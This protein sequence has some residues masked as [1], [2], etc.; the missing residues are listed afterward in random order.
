VALE[1]VVNLK[2]RDNAGDLRVEIS[3]RFAGNAVEEVSK[4]WT[5]ILQEKGRR[6]FTVDITNMSDYDYVGCSLLRNMGKHGVQIA[7]ASAA[8]LKFLAEISAPQRPGPAL[9]QSKPVH[10]K[11]ANKTSAERPRFAASGE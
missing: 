11:S 5:A 4:L 10:N 9:V 8:S 7:A 6:Q 3:G 1:T 2:V